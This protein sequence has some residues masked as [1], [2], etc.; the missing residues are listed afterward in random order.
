MLHLSCFAPLYSLLIYYSLE[1][2]NQS[3]GTDW[4]E[5][6]YVRIGQMSADGVGGPDDWGLF[7]MLGEG[8]VALD[9]SVATNN[10]AQNEDVDTQSIEDQGSSGSSA[11][12]LLTVAS[13]IAAAA[14][15]VN[16]L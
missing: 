2:W 11:C 8:V 3:W 1:P 6:G 4:G 9:A 14:Y 13:M 10:D 16:N 7:G 5:D 15:L 12:H